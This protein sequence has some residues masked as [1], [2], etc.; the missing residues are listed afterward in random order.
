VAARPPL[1]AGDAS[2]EALLASE[3]RRI[4]LDR[5]DPV[6]RGRLVRN[7]RIARGDAAAPEALYREALS[8]GMDRSDWVVER[9]LAERMAA[10]LRAEGAAQAVSEEALRSAYDRHRDVWT[11]PA[12]VQI[13]QL[14]FS[15][16]RR[17]ADA[18]PDAQAALAAL[19]AAGLGPDAAAG[20]GDPFLLGDELRP[21]S[22][23]ELARSFGPRFAAAVAALE[24]GAWSEP[25]E[26]SYGLHLVWVRAR[27]PAESIDFER[28]RPQVEDALRS[29]R[30]EAAL[31]AALASL[32][33]G[34][35]S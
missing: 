18:D 12:T 29:E 26:S 3:A 16:A 25:I 7:L 32:R 11:H 33:A 22:E 31:R 20:R 5:D 10:R 8:L 24:P 6:V 13:S 19:R 15:R 27:V 34:A 23:A 17:G 21:Q 2:D 1:A 28:V 14:F 30:G 4:G 9:R 35:G